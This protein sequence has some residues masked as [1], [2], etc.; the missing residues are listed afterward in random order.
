[1]M[2]FGNPESVDVIPKIPNCL[3]RKVKDFTLNN[4]NNF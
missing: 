1:M 2:W 4:I 3:I